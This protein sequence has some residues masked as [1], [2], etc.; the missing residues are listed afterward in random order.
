MAYDI[1][2]T[3]F[4]G[5]CHMWHCWCSTNGLPY[6]NPE[7]VERQLQAWQADMTG[8]PFRTRAELSGALSMAGLFVQT[9]EA[10]E[11]DLPEQV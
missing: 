8:S 4:E 3:T 9:F 10:A 11:R 5:L 7:D 2:M 1:Q 6:S